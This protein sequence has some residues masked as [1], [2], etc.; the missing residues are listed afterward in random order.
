MTASLRLKL[1]AA[2]LGIAT[3]CGPRQVE[4]RTAPQ[5]VDTT[6]APS[7]Q[8][9]NNLSQAVNVYVT[10]T[11]GKH[12][13]ESR[14]ERRRQRHDRVVQSRHGGRIAH[15]P[16]P[17]RAAFGELRVERALSRFASRSCVV[18]HGRLVADLR[19]HG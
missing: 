13:R 5:T 3:A 9:T 4:V 19:S 15:V 10:V 14:G 11:G 7:V 8:L 17:Q 6:G 16:E 18:R 2:A 1:L 12:R